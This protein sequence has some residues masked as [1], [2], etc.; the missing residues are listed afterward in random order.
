[1]RSH[2]LYERL[3]P[4]WRE[5][6]ISTYTLRMGRGRAPY[7]IGN[8]LQTCMG[9]QSRSTHGPTEIEMVR[10]RSLM[11]ERDR[12]THVFCSS[13]KECK[14]AWC[15]RVHVGLGVAGTPKILGSM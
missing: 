6:A 4:E 9:M 1:M 13:G 11:T 15:V 12:I 7:H 8:Y 2:P 14:N 10:L 5:F 3:R